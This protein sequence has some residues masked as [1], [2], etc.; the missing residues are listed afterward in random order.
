M[1]PF[2]RFEKM[3]LDYLEKEVEPL[4]VVPVEILKNVYKEKAKRFH[5]KCK[6]N[7]D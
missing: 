5:K 1:V 3:K 6:K 4:Q 2:I 7:S